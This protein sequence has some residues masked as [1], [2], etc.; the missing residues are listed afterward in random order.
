[1]NR[2]AL[3]QLLSGGQAAAR[4]GEDIVLPDK[5]VYMLRAEPC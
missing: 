5:W 2:N 3:S 4:G 1:M